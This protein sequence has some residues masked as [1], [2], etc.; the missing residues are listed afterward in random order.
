MKLVLV[1]FLFVNRHVSL[2][3][4]SY[5]YVQVLTLQE[6]QIPPRF[7]MYLVIN[8]CITAPIL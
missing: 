3:R 5:V 6:V 4:K 1:F 7:N 2:K 8:K